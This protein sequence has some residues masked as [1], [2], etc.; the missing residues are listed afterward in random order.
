[1]DEIEITFDRPDRTYR[2]GDEVTGKVVL[3]APYDVT[4]EHVQITWGWHTH[5]KGDRENGPEDN[6]KVGAQHMKLHRNE[7]VELPF[8]FTAPKGPATYHGK[9]LNLDWYMTASADRG[10]GNAAKCEK[11]FVLLGRESARPIDLGDQEGGLQG[12]PLWA[13]LEPARFRALQTPVAIDLP[14]DAEE[15]ALQPVLYVLG[16]L[17]LV[18]TVCWLATSIRPAIFALFFAAAGM[19][20]LVVAIT[21]DIAYKRQIELLDVSVEPRVVRQRDLVECHL[22]LLVKRDVRLDRI[23]AIIASQE[24]VSYGSDSTSETWTSGTST[25]PLSR[26]GVV[27][28]YNEPLTRGVSIAFRCAL[29]VTSEAPPTFKSDHNSVEWWVEFCVHLN[30]WPGVRRRFPITVLPD[31]QGTS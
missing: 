31:L 23:E 20:C 14:L 18:G 11:D 22:D 21:L 19:L 10:F 3:E 1:M 13:K 5:G 17:G 2:F 8:R 16:V 29:P 7:H 24:R 26:Q 12:L 30:G 25:H 9:E 15:M 4:Y 27:K 6:L 28:R